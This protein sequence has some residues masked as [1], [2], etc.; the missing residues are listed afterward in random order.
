MEEN[1]FSLSV[2]ARGTIG[3]KRILA[4]V[5]RSFLWGMLPGNSWDMWKMPVLQHG[6]Q[7]FVSMRFFTGLV[8]PRFKTFPSTSSRKIRALLQVATIYS[9]IRTL[10]QDWVTKYTS[11][12]P[13][14]FTRFL[15]NVCCFYLPRIHCQTSC[16]SL[17]RAPL[18][19]WMRKGLVFR[20]HQ[21]SG[22]LLS[23]SFLKSTVLWDLRTQLL[24]LFMPQI[25][26]SDITGEFNLTID[27]FVSPSRSSYATCHGFF[28]RAINTFFPSSL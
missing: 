27:S 15:H 18:G 20:C 8:L 1:L 3:T 10:N 6:M 2:K 14:W 26:Q 12:R 11:L 21:H 19:R 17:L 13:V 16:A 9:V 4:S 24:L 25:W 22:H 5:E 28:S 7:C 23:S